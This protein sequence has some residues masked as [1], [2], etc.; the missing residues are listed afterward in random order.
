M[1]GDGDGTEVVTERKR[2]IR[3]DGS[4]TGNINERI[5]SHHERLKR[6]C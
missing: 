3:G 1:Q 2:A 4:T 6:F 5:G